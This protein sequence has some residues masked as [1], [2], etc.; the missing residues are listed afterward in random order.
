MGKNFYLKLAATNL[1]RDR[2]MYI[3]FVIAYITMVSIYFMVI[4]IMFS[5]GISDVPAGDNL[6]I[7]FGIGMVVMTFLMILFMLYINSFLVK[8]RKKEFGLYGILGLEKRH[9]GKVIVLE[10]LILSG[11]SL[12]IGIISGC[13]FSKLIFML[14]YYSLNVTP[15]SRFDL[16]AEAFSITLLLFSVIFILTSL[17]NLLQVSLANPI[18]LLKGG[19]VGEKKVRFVFIKTILGLCILGWAYYAALSVNHALN[20]LTQFFIAVLAVIIAT[21]ILFQAGSLF[22]LT[23]LKKNKKFYYKANNF[24]SISGMF[25]RMKQN[26]AGLASICI[27]STM[28]LVTVSTVTALFLGQEG[29]LK[30]VNSDDISISIHEKLDKER[31]ENVIDLAQVSANKYNLEIEDV[32]YFNY[33]N[34]AACLKDGELSKIE[35]TKVGVDATA[36]DYYELVYEYI[37]DVSFVSLADYNRI[38]GSGEVLEEQQVI[39]LPGSN[40]EATSD[41]KI[42]GNYQVKSIQKGTKFI[43]RKNS[44]LDD[45]LF[46]VTASDEAERILRKLLVSKNGEEREQGFLAINLKDSKAAN[47]D[48]VSEFREK[49]LKAGDTISSRTIISDRIEGYGIYGGLLFLGVFFTIQFLAATILIIYFKQVSEGY[50]DKER[51]VILQKVGMDD[52]EVKRTINKQI[53]LVFFLPLASALVH[54]AFARHMII[55]LMEIFY[56]YDVALTTWCMV[57]TC[58]VFMLA[59]ILVYRLTAK[60]YYRLVRW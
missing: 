26:A 9:V 18:D 48:F 56:L 52:I 39:L 42:P 19:N 44:N 37:I 10:N 29:M 23:A 1:K 55:K 11:I 50:E 15:N 6:K 20:A 36:K 24:I 46:I 22:F 5:R 8:R 14:L 51:F 32:L 57:V 3:P 21:Y 40:V 45:R 31:F 54:V 27:L 16:P 25:Y 35:E 13:I 41:F 7:M 12:L 17:F 59:Y 47:M 38:N 28:V 33:S 30:I 43:E 60:V 34:V 2:K 4:T 53:L 49:L 58:I